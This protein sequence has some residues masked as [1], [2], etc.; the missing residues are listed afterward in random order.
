[1][2]CWGCQCCKAVIQLH[3]GG[4]R[5]GWAGPQRQIQ[6]ARTLALR[7][8]TALGSAAWV[9]SCC[10]TCAWT[11]LHCSGEEWPANG[12][13]SDGSRTMN[14]ISSYCHQ[15]HYVQQVTSCVS[16]TARNTKAATTTYRKAHPPGHLLSPC[17]L[18]YLYQQWLAPGCRRAHV[19]CRGGTHR[20]SAEQAAP[21]IPG[22]L[23]PARCLL[24]Q[25]QRGT[26]LK[27]TDGA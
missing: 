19:S 8:W 17:L 27:R 14:W 15:L 6:R 16:K 18:L 23:R 13:F 24:A 25:L 10:C 12:E 22:T 11:I 21:R 20:P 9:Y 2:G 4:P 3:H 1:M 5:R 7:C 26:S